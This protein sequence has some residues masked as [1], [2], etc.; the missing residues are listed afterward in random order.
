MANRDVETLEEVLLSFAVPRGLLGHEGNSIVVYCVESH[1]CS[2]VNHLFFINVR[3]FK[4]RGFSY[5][6]QVR[7]GRELH[8][9]LAV[10]SWLGAVCSSS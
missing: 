9:E 3:S 7:Q 10:L 2:R 5:R 8:I 1:G 4:K 6:R